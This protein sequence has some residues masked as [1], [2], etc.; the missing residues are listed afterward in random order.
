MDDIGTPGT[1]V[2][3]ALNT[4]IDAV[5]DAALTPSYL[6]DIRE[7]LADGE[8]LIRNNTGTNHVLFQRAI[9]ALTV[10]YA[11]Q[12]GTFA[13]IGYQI[14]V[15]AGLYRFT[16]KLT[17]KTGVGIR[18]AGM[19]QTIFYPVGN[20]SF[21]DG[22]YPGAG[23]T[24]DDCT[25]QDFDVDGTSQTNSSYTTQIKGIFI[26]YMKR[27]RWERVRVRN[28]WATG[29]GVDHLEGA[30]FVDCVAEGCGRGIFE[31]SV[32]PKTA[33]G[34]SGFGIG[35]G[36][37]PTE[38]VTIINCTSRNNGIYGFFTEKQNGE[39]Y[40]PNGF[41][42]IGSHGEG[43][44]IGFKDCG[45]TGAIV[46]GN[47]FIG[48]RYAGV[49]IDDTILAP[50][51]GVDGLIRGNVISGNG[52]SPLT[53]TGAGVILGKASTGGYTIASNEIFGNTGY[54]ICIPS[55]ADL[56]AGVCIDSNRVHSNTLGGIAVLGSTSY[57][58]IQRN[59]LFSNAGT[60]LIIGDATKN[61][62]NFAL[63]D[64]D[65]RRATVTFTQSAPGAEIARNM[66]YRSDKPSG[67]TASSTSSTQL[68]ISWSQPTQGVPTSYTLEHMPAGGS[69]TAITLG[70]PTAT[71]VTKTGLTAGTVYGLRVKATFDGVDSD[72]VYA[73]AAPNMALALADNFNRAD[74]PAGSMGSTSTGAAAWSSGTWSIVNTQAYA[75]TTS[76]FAVV[77]AGGT[78]HWVKATFAGR[79]STGSHTFGLLARYTSTSAWVGLNI[80][81]T[82]SEWLLQSY[83]GSYTTLLSTGVTAS[84]GDVVE[85]AVY[86]T[87]FTVIINGVIKG[88]ATSSTA[89]AATQIGLRG[90]AAGVRADDLY[91]WSIT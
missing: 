49:A 86:G 89:S 62:S 47:H 36:G 76:A 21:I 85:V 59:T 68:D 72:W 3:D 20:Q 13:K 10:E 38:S 44:W 42:L 15:P 48:N 23:Y 28:T 88:T 83:T 84:P 58:A 57:L 25:F 14:V 64:N 40:Y 29:F 53:Y 7:F 17:W 11:A 18:G 46:Q 73:N 66:G 16:T 19:G 70:S 43:N 61:A 24:F 35:T 6:R 67:L 31:K 50:Q 30:I 82:T 91:C 52:G 77:G 27:A 9:D 34:G 39:T 87:T 78:N 26:Q 79:I 55:T 54:G 56:G 45:S 8:T 75:T 2:G 1:P 22:S 60:D 90:T 65:L 12:S 32:D 63:T 69:W 51:G 80:S 71:S 37:S 74:A 81:S 5:V 41:R 4:T 33:S